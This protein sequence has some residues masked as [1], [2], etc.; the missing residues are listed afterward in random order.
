MSVSRWRLRPLTRKPLEAAGTTLSA[1]SCTDSHIRVDTRFIGA[2]ENA[3]D[4][5]IEAGKLQEARS[6]IDE[7]ERLALENFGSESVS[8]GHIL[9]VRG[10]LNIHLINYDR[11]LS[12][13]EHAILIY[14]S[15][16]PETRKDIP[17]LNG[18]MAVTDSEPPQHM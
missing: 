17:I 18:I 16:H 4:G 10:R 13:L 1:E 12:D 15:K 9:A 7:S 2:L 8:H 14:G 11:A 5:A 6:L 3:A